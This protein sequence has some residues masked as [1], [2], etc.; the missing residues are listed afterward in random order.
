MKTTGTIKTIALVL[1]LLLQGAIAYLFVGYW[2]WHV[3]NILEA[4]LL[5]T[6]L[7][8]C[9]TAILFLC[10]VVAEVVMFVRRKS[11]PLR[12]AFMAFGGLVAVLFLETFGTMF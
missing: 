6:V 5:A 10:V 12:V 3:G 8:Q 11:D 4:P 9:I 1:V 7:R 2:W